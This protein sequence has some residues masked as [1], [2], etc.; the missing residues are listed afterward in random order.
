MPPKMS[1]TSKRKV[2]RVLS[3]QKKSQLIQKVRSKKLAMILRKYH[4]R[5]NLI[6]LL[7]VRGFLEGIEAT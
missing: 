4:L 7:H 6:I 1:L 2:K 3:L 5:I